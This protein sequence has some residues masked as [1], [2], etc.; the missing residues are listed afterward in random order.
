M[1]LLVDVMKR[2][3]EYLNVILIK[4]VEKRNFFEK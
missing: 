1:C 2:L 4:K 3:F